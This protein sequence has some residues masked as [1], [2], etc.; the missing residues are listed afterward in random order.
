MKEP[1]YL[2][3]PFLF[4]K[5]S[6]TIKD[7]NISLVFHLPWHIHVEQR[8]GQNSG[9]TADKT[10]THLIC[11]RLV[12]TLNKERKK[13]GEFFFLELSIQKHSKRKEKL[14]KTLETGQPDYEKC[15]LMVSEGLHSQ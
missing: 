11:D 3:D 4:K 10:R 14:L 2:T 13:W 6:T 7:M 8:K 12:V 15:S 5:E 1:Q 9:W